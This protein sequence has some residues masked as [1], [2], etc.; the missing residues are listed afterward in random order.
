MP[1]PDPFRAN[2]Q[3]GSLLLGQD[4]PREA[5]PFIQAAIAANPDS[6]EG[7]AEL[8][9][10]W[11]A[12]PA[13]RAKSIPAIDRAICLAPNSSYYHGLKGWF[14]VCL[15]RYREALTVAQKGLAIDPEC[16][17]SLNS[18]ANAYTRLGLW[19]GA[20]EACRRILALNPTD[21]PALNLLAQA[22]RRQGQYKQSRETVASLL[23]QLPNNAFGHAN[24]GYDAL[25][26]GDHHRATGHFRE[27]LRLDPRFDYARRGL[28]RSMRASVWINDFNIRA[29]RSLTK[30][31]TFEKVAMVL[32]AVALIL[33]GGAYLVDLI[34]A[35]APKIPANLPTLLYFGFMTYLYVSI[36]F[37]GIGTFL[38]FFDPLGRHVMTGREKVA[39]VFRLLLALGVLMG[40]CWVGEW[41]SVLGVTLFFAV[42]L[43]CQLISVLRD[44]WQ[45]RRA[46][47]SED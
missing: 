28:I 40:L 20:E 25:A 3:R 41:D 35:F 19:E 13:T 42:A 37:A 26:I 36:V 21:G 4:R 9:R 5:L 24:A 2:L 34:N 30:P 44:S 1:E 10:C 27:S 16:S 39:A 22:L 17:R 29:G 47:R 38:L 43:C 12:L 8:A 32:F 45:R 14:L 18:L 31:L 23:A 7:Y 33:F 15:M 46:S 6:P 11:N